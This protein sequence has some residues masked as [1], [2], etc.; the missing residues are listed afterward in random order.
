MTPHIVSEERIKL[1]AGERCFTLGQQQLQKQAPTAVAIFGD[2]AKARI[3]EFSVELS[4]RGDTVEGNCSCPDSEGFEFCQHC[5]SLALFANQQGQQVLSLSKG[6]D[7][8]K[9]LA[10]L[11]SLEKPVLAKQMLGLLEQ[12][13]E[14]FKRYL[15]KASLDTE[16]LDYVALKKELTALTRPQSQMFSQ[17]Q[18]KHFFSRIERFLE[19]V[20][21]ANY[22][23]QPE[24]MLK[25][26]EYAI[27]RINL[28][29]A[30]VEDRNGHRE[31]TVRYLHEMFLS[32][33][34]VQNGR[35]ETVCKRFEKNW[36]EDR[37][38]VLDL[39]PECYFS[40]R[41]ALL[42]LLQT[43]LKASWKSA[44][45]PNSERELSVWQKQKIARYFLEHDA[46]KISF[47][48][49]QSMSLVL[50]QTDQDYLRVA[51][52]WASN[53]RPDEA[54]AIISERIASGRL[55]Q[56]ILI[57]AADISCYLPDAEDRLLV[58]LD[59]FPSALARPVLDSIA[60]RKFSQAFLQKAVD[61]LLGC[62]KPEV[63]PL[64]LPHLISSGR[65]SEALQVIQGSTVDADV[66][67]QSVIHLSAEF[68][69]ECIKT[70]EQK[71]AELLDKRMVSADVKAARLM[72]FLESIKPKT[73]SIDAFVARM[74][75]KFRSRPK[76]V[77]SYEQFE[78]N[79]FK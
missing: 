77:E 11:L 76:F 3:G 62:G 5:V 65:F 28:L 7:K 64:V 35:P 73:H 21:E 16:V 39:N 19:E 20:R 17:R 41:L 8:S 70:L 2:T 48:E 68:P 52:R 71:I 14:Q 79:S 69:L 60:P 22:L 67:E 42:T 46:E 12:D 74:Q 4:Y 9:I 44:C 51:E 13:P 29:L 37:F 24:P 32:L 59:R 63:L 72:H 40:E 38:Q 43:R 15:L 30:K 10:Y 47:E 58:L 61:L 36:L 66:L 34:E 75:P 1:I 53:G 49:S 54:I 26:L 78:A 31:L 56:D 57:A 6:P 25:L 18:V 50:A 55:H 45:W 23:A 33:F 27:A